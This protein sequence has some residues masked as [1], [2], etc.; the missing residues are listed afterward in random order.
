MKINFS[1]V[2]WQITIRDGAYE[3]IPKTAE[4]NWVWSPQGVIDMHQPEMWAYL[5]FA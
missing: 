1:R 5:E 3:K 4:D 2:E